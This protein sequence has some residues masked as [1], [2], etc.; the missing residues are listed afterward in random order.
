MTTRILAVLLG[1]AAGSA[2]AQ[3]IGPI[4]ASDLNGDGRAER[5]ALIDTGDGAA[6]LQIENTGWG[7]GVIYAE[8]IAWVG[9]I[10]QRP[11]LSLAP[12]GSVRL[13]SMNEAIGRRRWELSL[14]IAHRNDAYTV[15]GVTFRWRDTIDNTDAGVCDVNLLTGRGTLWRDGRPEQRFRTTAKPRPATQ[16]KDDTPLPKDCGLPN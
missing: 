1:L 2:V 7:N 11:E 15:A 9:G 14:T 4:V 13:T 5:F 10:G 8:R 3:T 12:N 16:W 6:D